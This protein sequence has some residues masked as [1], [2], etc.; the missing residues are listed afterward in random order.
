MATKNP[1]SR[2]RI[3]ALSCGSFVRVAWFVLI[4]ILTLLSIG[5][6]LDQQAGDD[7]KIAPFVPSV[8]QDATLEQLAYD[9]TNGK[10]WGAAVEFS[11][12]WLGRNPVSADALA[13]IAFA[14][15]MQGENADAMA[16]LALALPRGWRAASA[17][18]MA[19]GLAMASNQPDVAAQ[20][21]MA[22][23]RQESYGRSLESLSLLVLQDPD[24]LTTF[25]HSMTPGNAWWSTRFL[26]LVQSRLPARTVEALAK[27]MKAS[28]MQVDCPALSGD[29]RQTAMSGRPLVALGLWGNL[30]AG[31]GMTRP[32]DM[33]FH[34]K[35][36]LAGPFDWN[37]PP[38]PG[39]STHL[40]VSDRRA[41][42]V[43][44]NAQP[45]AVK[46]AERAM[47][48]PPGEWLLQVDMRSGSSFA[49]GRLDAQITCAPVDG[50]QI[51]LQLSQLSQEQTK[52][53]IPADKCAAQV[54]SLYSQRGEGAI[55]G[56]AFVRAH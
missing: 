28:D 18:R 44:Y 53:T 49:T 3:F 31:Q 12:A 50:S 4:L 40:D 14:R 11:Q 13:T 41:T 1:N 30:C 45:V 42:L 35:T 39:L 16:A 19:I 33:A 46:I 48:L 20:R 56:V 21:L 6:Q 51:R 29:V 2:E 24:A 7:S 27:S 17:Q 25:N 10:D 36:E 26:R 8:M 34:N 32:D 37:L 22:M 15:S 47:T 5:A 55:E 9:A 38:S 23:W 54:F 43:Y 52:F